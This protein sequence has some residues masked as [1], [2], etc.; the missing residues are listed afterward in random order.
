M[1]LVIVDNTVETFGDVPTILYPALELLGLDLSDFELSESID[2]VISHIDKNYKRFSFYRKLAIH[3][4]L[5]AT[6]SPYPINNHLWSAID[7]INRDLQSQ[8][9]RL[10]LNPF[11]AVR[12]INRDRIDIRNSKE[13]A[14][15]IHNILG[16]PPE[17]E[18]RRYDLQARLENSTIDSLKDFCSELYQHNVSQEH[19]YKQLIKSK[20]GI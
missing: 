13:A 15:Y 2:N 17:V 6:N 1:S 20:W 18:F 8:S 9:V 3:N 10:Y 14:I 11:T 16:Q 5:I 7:S 19:I 12:N 4:L